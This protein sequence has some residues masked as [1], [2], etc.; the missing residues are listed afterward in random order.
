[1]VRR[2]Y[3]SGYAVEC[4]LKACVLAHI[5][6]TGAIFV[7][8]KYAEKC[9]THNL[10]SLLNRANLDTVMAAES[11]A[12]I[13][14]DQNWKCARDWDESSRYRQFTQNQAQTMYDAIADQVNGVLPWIRKRW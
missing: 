6:A 2:Y 11:S 14:L 8:K 5:E 7:D 3:L 12:N 4:G 1:M 9:W 10:E 13:A